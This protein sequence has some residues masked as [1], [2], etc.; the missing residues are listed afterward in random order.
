MDLFKMMKQAN[1]IRSKAKEMEKNLSSQKFDVDLKGVMVTA[2]AKQDILDIKIDDALFN[3]GRDVVQKK[4]LSAV[5]EALKKGR[6]IMAAE[7]KKI[8]GNVDMGGLGK[9]LK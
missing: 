8:M 1:Q 7:T 2:N 3:Q 5:Q 4:V 6:D 9:M